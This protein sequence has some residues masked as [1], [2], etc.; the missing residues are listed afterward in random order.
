M[1]WEAR[2]GNVPWAELT[3]EWW[4]PLTAL[5]LHDGG[6][7]LF[8]NAVGLVLLGG[9][10]TRVMGWWRFLVLFFAGGYSA[11]LASALVGNFDLAIGASSGV[12]ALL[13]GGAVLI[14]AVRVPHYAAA[15]RRTLGLLGLVVAVDFLVATQAVRVDYVA[16]LG[17]LISGIVIAAALWL[18][19]QKLGRL[20]GDGYS[21]AK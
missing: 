16:H 12:Y 2:F 21:S 13:G 10:V 8:I 1:E 17:G 18:P 19:R 4:R 14:H 20:P 15:R 5:F 7:H 3:G 9:V 11:N 6:V